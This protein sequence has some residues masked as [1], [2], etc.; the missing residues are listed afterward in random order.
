MATE[1]NKDDEFEIEIDKNAPTLDDLVSAPEGA[2]GTEKTVAADPLPEPVG[3]AEGIEE[4]KR[5]LD[6]ANQRAANS[7]R[8]AYE[9]ANRANAEFH[10]AENSDLQ[11][12]EAGIASITRDNEI[13][14]QNMQIYLSEGK[15][16][17]VAEI[18]ERMAENA[19]ARRELESGKAALQNALKQ[20]PK[21]IEVPKSSDPVEAFASQ[22]KP[23]SADWVRKHPDYVTDQ[24]LNE[25]LRRA[26]K[27][28]VDE[29]HAIDSHGY[30]KF[31]E[32]H[33]GL[34]G[35][36]PSPRPP[37]SQP[38]RTEVD[39][40]N[41][42]SGAAAPTRQSVPV[43]AP[44]SRAGAGTGT[45]RI[46]LTPAEAEAAKISGVSPEEYWKNKQAMLKD[47]KITLN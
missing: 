14:K 20:A 30:F 5:K 23:A 16:D 10:R 25:Q 7:E 11:V 1:M 41:P 27:D 3:D 46:R 32:S 26:H 22:L 42:M 31:I 17:K 35:G 39:T 45:Q 19:A 29:G 9:L 47:G 43:S 28:A 40:D 37:A 13:L 24:R 2:A 18:N 4:L 44:V 21:T 36:A 33:L 15:F 8:V 12:I 6:T 34:S 38:R